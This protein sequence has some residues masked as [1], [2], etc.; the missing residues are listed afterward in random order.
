MTAFHFASIFVLLVVACSY[1]TCHAEESSSSSSCGWNPVG[2]PVEG[3]LGDFFGHY[4]ALS[5]DGRT[6]L[7]GAPTDGPQSQ[8]VTK[9]FRYRPKEDK[10]DMAEFYDTVNGTYLDFPM[11]EAA[12]S[13]WG[14]VLNGTEPGEWFGTGVALS[15]NGS[16]IAI[17]G[18]GYDGDAAY[19]DDDDI[20]FIQSQ[21]VV[22]VYIDEQR[23]HENSTSLF[24]TRRPLGQT[25]H[26]KGRS[27]YFG[28]SVALSDNGQVLAVAAPQFQGRGGYVQ[29]YILETTTEE[30]VPMGNA[31][32]GS[33]PGDQFGISISLSA[34]GD[35]I[36]IGA[37]QDYVNGD[38]S[39]I[40]YAQVYEFDFD[41][42][43]W[44]MLG[45]AFVGTSKT[46]YFGAAVALSG[47]GQTLALGKPMDNRAVSLAAAA[48]AN[49][50]N[51]AVEV[52]RFYPERSGWSLIG[53]T[54]VGRG[55]YFG[56]TLALSQ[57]G[58]TL[59]VGSWASTDPKTT[60]LGTTEA[61]I[62]KLIIDEMTTEWHLTSGI[63][64]VGT[65]MVGIARESSM[66]DPEWGFSASFT[67]KHTTLVIGGD[68]HLL[69][70]DNAHGYVAAYRVDEVDSRGVETASK[71]K[72]GMG[73]DTDT[74][75]NS[76]MLCD[77]DCALNGDIMDLFSGAVPL[78]DRSGTAATSFVA[79]FVFGGVV[80]ALQLFL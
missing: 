70:G 33:Q 1:K 11:A 72:S 23:E 79:A 58:A 4:V 76:S 40:G 60:T 49:I 54:I 55:L 7:V 16:I 25:L 73:D 14:Q 68:Y 38:D 19:K 41:K 2:S 39:K 48:N 31:I 71:G 80:M 12:W 36:A 15:H 34:A 37:N 20:E 66:D 6:M 28:E 74:F 17:G 59:A 57:D 42:N 13:L 3:R 32:Y 63:L 27:D 43:D 78:E 47:D 21:G 64:N 65:E 5:G 52:F 62:Y 75:F 45:G 77:L 67:D 56:R 69:D 10:D 44:A 50:A 18:S 30:W 9:V 22:R 8:G 26:G 35:R 29:V 51:G 53:G 46:I 61:A 24:W